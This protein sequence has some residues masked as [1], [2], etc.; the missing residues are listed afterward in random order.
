MVPVSHQGA[1]SALENPDSPLSIKVIPLSPHVSEYG[2]PGHCLG[3]AWADTDNPV[4][5][6][7]IQEINAPN[8]TQLS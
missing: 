4:Y 3:M 8:A 2:N 5:Q 1:S 7:G 6:I